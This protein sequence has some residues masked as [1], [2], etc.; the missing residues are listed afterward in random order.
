M[1]FARVALV[2]LV[3]SSPILPIAVDPTTF[4][5]AARGSLVLGSTFS[6]FLST[7]RFFA[8][9]SGSGS[10]FRFFTC[11]SSL[12]GPSVTFPLPFKSLTSSCSSLSTSIAFATG[13][14]VLLLTTLNLTE[15]LATAGFEELLIGALRVLEAVERALDGLFVFTVD[16]LTAF[17]ED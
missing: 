14:F 9:P 15:S 6:S 16:G 3:T 2:V 1:Y 17:F 12:S 10:A 5:L 11:N 4:L 8:L 13:T 7:F